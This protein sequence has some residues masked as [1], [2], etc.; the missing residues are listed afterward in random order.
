[1]ITRTVLPTKL[2]ALFTITIRAIGQIAH[3]LVLL[4]SGF[5]QRDLNLVTRGQLGLQSA[6]QLIQAQ[7]GHT[8]QARHLRQVLVIGQQTRVQLARQVRQAGV[9]RHRATGAI[10]VNGQVQVTH[11]PHL[12]QH[13]EAALATL[14]LERLLRVG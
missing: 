10:F 8:T 4:T 7:H 1:M 14:G 11:R 9:H 5:H 3:A 6:A 13:G 2:T 12:L